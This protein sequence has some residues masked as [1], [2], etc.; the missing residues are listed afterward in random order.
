MKN[1]IG[2][3]AAGVTGLLAVRA[4]GALGHAENLRG[5]RDVLSL[6]RISA[7]TGQPG[8]CAI[9]TIRPLE[10]SADVQYTASIDRAMAASGFAIAALAVTGAFFLGRRA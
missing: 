6:L 8:A 5:R 9:D 3:V 7:D 2:Y 1:A 10:G 4:L